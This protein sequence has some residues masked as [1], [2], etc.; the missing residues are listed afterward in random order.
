MP[1]ARQFFRRTDVVRAIKAVTEAGLT[2]ST[3]RISP[4]GQIEVETLKAQ[5]QDSG[6][7]LDKWLKGRADHAHS[8]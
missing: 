8:A 2:V 7:D 1:K 6:T 5:A 3:V 4:Q